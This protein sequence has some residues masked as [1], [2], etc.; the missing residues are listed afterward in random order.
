[1]LTGRRQSWSGRRRECAGGAWRHF[2][3]RYSVFFQ[4]SIRRS[5][6]PLYSSYPNSLYPQVQCPAHK[7]GAQLC[8]GRFVTGLLSW[9]CA[10][11]WC[12]GCPG[13]FPLWKLYQVT[14]F[15]W[16]PDL[17]ESSAVQGEPVFP[18]ASRDPWDPHRQ[19]EGR[20]QSWQM[21]VCRA[22]LCMPTALPA[23]A[24][25][26]WKIV[27][28]SVSSEG[29]TSITPTEELLPSQAGDQ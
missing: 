14:G 8:L 1:M 26:S 6:L 21:P 16:G 28:N 2:V 5:K 22:L 10:G 9:G 24:N 7:E 20:V 13:G 29:L 19:G 3:S 17:L 18:K 23:L 12:A 27:E 4:S 15:I 25:L 11:C